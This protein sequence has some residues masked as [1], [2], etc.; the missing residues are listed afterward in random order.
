[1]PVGELYDCGDKELL[2]RWHE[3][4]DLIRDYNKTDSKD[5]ESKEKILSKLLCKKGKISGLPP[6]FTQT[7]ETI[8][9]L[10]T[11]AKSI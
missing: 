3:V 9:I 4:K 5:M 2:D 8:S 1:M 6:R 10:A 11:T 7:M